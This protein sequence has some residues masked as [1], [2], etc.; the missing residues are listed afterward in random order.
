MY[1]AIKFNYRKLACF[2]FRGE[3]QGGRV[4]NVKHTKLESFNFRNFNNIINRVSLA[5]FLFVS[6]SAIIGVR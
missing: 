3:W 5:V 4:E 6:L 1:V 2:G